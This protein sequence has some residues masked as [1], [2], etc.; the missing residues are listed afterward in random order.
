MPR[1]APG[2]ARRRR[3]RRRRVGPLLLVLILA[4][5]L[6][7]VSSD[8]PR[9]D[10]R[11]LV[12]PRTYQELSARIGTFLDGVTVSPQAA[13][14]RAVAMT[15]PPTTR[16]SR[17][18][19]PV[20]QEESGDRLLPAV[21]V[22]QESPAYRFAAQQDDGEDPVAWSPCR[23]IRYV[24]NGDG[25]PAGFADTVDEAVAD[26]SAAT[27][28]LFVDDGATSEQPSADRGAY[29]PQR[30]GDRW[31]PVLISAADPETVGF[32]AG[33]TAGVA[34]TYRVQ[35]RSSE[36]WHLV[37]GSV[38]VDREVF[39]QRRAVDGEPGWVAVLRHELGHLAG[40]DHLDDP[41]QLMNPV[42]S[43]AVRDYQAGDRT[44]LALLG[45]GTCAPDA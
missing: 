33:D 8:D 31:A 15:P 24:V 19:P 32:L 37:S 6:W 17:A 45:Q 13:P 4:A 34:Y 22:E 16:T 35:G 28:L 14:P 29:L 44:G 21:V 38:F 2:A 26:L 7:W 9:G 5:G 25:A 39:D 41:S 40:L 42:T 10:L 12:D 1:P 30:Y 20:G 27:G 43:S 11:A 23:P 18:T 36:T 3:R